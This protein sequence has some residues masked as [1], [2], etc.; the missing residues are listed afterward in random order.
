MATTLS[1]LVFNI[2][3]IKGGGRSSD[4]ERLSARQV[5]FQIGYIRSLLIRRDY[6]KGRS[7]NP[8][9]EQDLGC[10]PVE[11]VDKADCCEVEVGCTILRTVNPVPTPIEVFDRDLV[12]YVGSVDKTHSFDEISP[13]RARF[14][15]YNKYTRGKTRWFYMGDYIYILNNKDLKYINIRGIFEDPREAASYSHCT[16]EPCFT[17]DSDYPIASWMIQPVTEMILKG[18]V[19]ESMIFPQDNKNDA[20]GSPTQPPVINP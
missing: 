9:T 17:M 11:L 2:L 15:N 18:E 20:S 8:I 10:V 1:K 19:K 5:E 4:D 12:T 3:N 14:I 6:E 16:G 13:A 7:I